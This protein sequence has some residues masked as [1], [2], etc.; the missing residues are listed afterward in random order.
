M[1]TKIRRRLEQEEGFTL[2]ELLV[3]ILIIG[4]LA[5]VAI[6]TFLSQKN[7]AYDSNAQSNLKNAQTIVESYANGNNGQY[8]AGAHQ[9]LSAVLTNDSDTASLSATGNVQDV[10]YSATAGTS[11]S[12][13]LCAEGSANST[14][15]YWWI[16]VQN[17][18]TTYDASTSMACSGSYTATS[19]ASTSGFPSL[20]TT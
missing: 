3:V 16:S 9:V 6:P 14:P 12:Y 7:K 15:H 1:L 10:F 4:I 17:G 8:P 11:D 2:I 19:L 18:T 5:A 20:Q 13:T